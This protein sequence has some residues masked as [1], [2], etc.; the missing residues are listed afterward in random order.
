MVDRIL[1]TKAYFRKQWRHDVDGMSTSPILNLSVAKNH[2]DP[3]GAF[4]QGGIQKALLQDLNDIK[5][6]LKRV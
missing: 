6:P 2:V 5:A 3:N 4:C 1:T